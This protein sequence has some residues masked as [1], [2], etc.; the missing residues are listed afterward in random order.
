MRGGAGPGGENCPKRSRGFCLGL[1][2]GSRR[3]KLACKHLP[4]RGDA[5]SAADC[6]RGGAIRVGSPRVVVEAV[7]VRPGR[8]VESSREPLSM[9]A[10]TGARRT[11]RGRSAPGRPRLT[12]VDVVVGDCLAE[13]AKQ[14]RAGRR[15]EHGAVLP[16]P[17]TGTGPC[18][19]QR[20]LASNAAFCLRHRI[21]LGDYGDLQAL[22]DRRVSPGRHAAYAGGLPTAPTPD[23]ND[24]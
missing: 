15:P 23:A 16:G 21:T 5:A 13:L 7:V 19:W 10:T 11:G 20:R 22:Q 1:S 12:V 8:F 18:A 24:G 17:L 4:W 14:R 3:P 9:L 2:H 6:T